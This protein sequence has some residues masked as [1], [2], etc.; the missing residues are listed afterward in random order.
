MVYFMAFNGRCLLSKGSRLSDVANC[1]SVSKRFSHVSGN[2]NRAMLARSKLVWRATLSEGSFKTISRVFS[3]TYSFSC[4]AYPGK[5]ANVQS[6]TTVVVFQLEYGNVARRSYHDIA[7]NGCT[8]A[9]YMSSKVGRHV[10]WTRIHSLLRTVLLHVEPTAF[11][12]TTMDI[13]LTS[14]RIVQQLKA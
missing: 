3:F 2:S 7:C 11:L 13:N 4:P 5:W 14:Y 12:A 6:F 1:Q 9:I 8:F 10:R